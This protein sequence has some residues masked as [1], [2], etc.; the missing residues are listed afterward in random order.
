[1]QVKKQLKRPEAAPTVKLFLRVPAP[2]LEQIWKW[3]ELSH[4]SQTQEA[5][6]LIR[7]A[8]EDRS[9]SK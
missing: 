9:Y 3:A 4:R 7:E 5:L 8:L 6:E 1:M 2:L